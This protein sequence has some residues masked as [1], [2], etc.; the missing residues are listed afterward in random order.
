MR[1]RHGSQERIKGE[2]RGGE[3]LDAEKQSFQVAGGSPG[4]QVTGRVFTQ[5]ETGDRMI[6]W[7][8]V[9][10]SILPGFRSPFEFHGFTSAHKKAPGFRGLDLRLVS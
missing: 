9:A 8:Y 5:R 4:W 10:R 7:G 3:G 6:G 1:F 2:R